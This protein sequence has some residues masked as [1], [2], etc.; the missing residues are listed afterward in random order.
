MGEAYRD[1]LEKVGSKMIELFRRNV[2]LNSTSQLICIGNRLASTRD[3]LDIF[4]SIRWNSRHEKIIADTILY[5]MKEGLK[6]NSSTFF[7]SL[8]W[9]LTHIDEWENI[10]S[11]LADLLNVDPEFDKAGETELLEQ[12]VR[13]VV[14]SDIHCDLFREL[15]STIDELSDYLEESTDDDDFDQYAYLNAYIVSNSDDE[16]LRI[17]YFPEMY[18]LFWSGKLP[19]DGERITKEMLKESVSEYERDDLSIFTNESKEMY[20]LVLNAATKIVGIHHMVTNHEYIDASWKY[21]REKAKESIDLKRHVDPVKGVAL[22]QI[23]K[24]RIAKLMGG[25]ALMIVTGYNAH[26]KALLIEDGFYAAVESLKYGFR[27]SPAI[28]LRDA[29]IPIVA[30]SIGNTLD[31]DWVDSYR[32]SQICLR[33]LLQV[34]NLLLTSTMVEESW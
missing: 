24:E 27:R 28:G 19:E 6:D 20:S 16:S 29:G 4:A 25:Y 15:Y 33:K 17:S 26:E 34:S 12:L 8:G 21:R 13:G 7:L 9:I 3:G 31:P 11:G 10:S 22:F 2:G 14:K 30:E 1:A 5:S 23:Y 18:P 32:S